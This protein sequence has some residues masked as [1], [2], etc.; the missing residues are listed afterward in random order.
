MLV[1]PPALTLITDTSRYSGDAFFDI[2]E[3]ALTAG[4]DAVLV[5]ETALSSA[6]LLVL[7]A[8]LREMT[9]THDARLIIHSQADIAEA[10][11][12]DGVHLSARDIGS[13]S[14]VRGWLNDPAKTVSASCHHARELSLAAEAGA[15]FAMLSPVFPTATHAGA[16]CLGIADFRRLADQALLPVVALGGITT[17]N[18]A[19]LNWPHLAVISAILSAE[20]PAAA[21]RTLLQSCQ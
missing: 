10:V 16:P 9:Q 4:V 13:I 8:R 14:A 3:Q 7:A 6:R 1:V 19:E 5:R 21:T 12:A 2:L 18:C 17:H 15:D 11:D 20:A